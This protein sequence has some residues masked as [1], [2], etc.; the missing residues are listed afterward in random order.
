MGVKGQENRDIM[1]NIN[2]G[3]FSSAE[4]QYLHTVE[5]INRSGYGRHSV[6]IFDVNY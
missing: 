2:R 6:D 1:K 4:V 3:K 5:Q